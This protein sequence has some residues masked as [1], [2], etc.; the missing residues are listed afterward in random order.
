MAYSKAKNGKN[1]TL[2]RTMFMSEHKIRMVKMYI[3]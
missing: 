2:N 1:N 3:L